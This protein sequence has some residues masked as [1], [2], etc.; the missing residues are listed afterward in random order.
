MEILLKL[1]LQAT[2]SLGFLEKARREIENL[3]RENG[4]DQSSDMNQSEIDN[5][6]DISAISKLSLIMKK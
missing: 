1:N 2:N 5:T 6:E 3:W 4:E